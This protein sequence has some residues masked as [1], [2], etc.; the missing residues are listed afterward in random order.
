MGGL[1]RMGIGAVL[2]FDGEAAVASM[3]R[4][5]RSVDHLRQGFGRIGEG[6]RT[7]LGGVTTAAMA[8][9]PAVLA[10]GTAAAAA[11]HKYASFE[12]GLAK[13][14]SLLDGGMA[15][16]KQYSSAIESMALRFGKS[17]DDVSE[18]AFQALSAGIK[19]TEMMD[20]MTEATKG[21]VAGF[22]DTAKSVDV[23]TTAMNAWGDQLG[24]GQTAAQKAKHLNDVL[25]LANKY[26]KTT[27]EEL[28]ASLGNVAGT[29]ATA[30]V[31][32][33][34]VGAAIAAMTAAGISTPE[35]VTALNQALLSFISP[36]K[37]ALKL[38]PGL[39]KLLSLQA[40]RAKGLAG[41]L[42]D[43]T[44]KVQG[45]DEAIAHIFGNVRAFKAVIALTGQGGE[46][47]RK[48]SGE[49]RNMAGITDKV[50]GDVANTL[51]NRFA[52]TTSAAALLA[53]RAGKGLAE[54]LGLAGAG[55]AADLLA[56][57]LDAV[58]QV[59]HRV[60]AAIRGSLERLQVKERIEQIGQVLDTVR[61]KLAE[62]FGGDTAQR[63]TDLA[64][65]GSLIAAALAPVALVLA[66]VVGILAGMITS[67]SGVVSMLGGM[68][69]VATG[70][71]EAFAAVAGIGGGPLALIL[72]A[73]AAAVYAVMA[74]FNGC[75]DSLG[76]L[77][78]S[79][80][81][82]WGAIMR[83]VDVLVSALEPTFTAIA[84]VLGGV[85]S[86]VAGLAAAAME[87]LAPAFELLGSVVGAILSVV[88]T[89][90]AA[91]LPMIGRMFGILGDVIREAVVPA[92]RVV[93]DV[94]RTVSG[95]LQRFVDMLQHGIDSAQRMLGLAKDLPFVNDTPA[96]KDRAA[97]G[98]AVDGAFN[99]VGAGV[100]SAKALAAK[101]GD[102]FGQMLADASGLES[103]VK[104]ELLAMASNKQQ[105]NINNKL[106]V[107]GGAMNVASG[108]ARLELME[109]AGAGV[110]PWQ[111]RQI[112]ERGA[113]TVGAGARG[114]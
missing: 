75:R 71:G 31:P 61:T 60:G 58:E 35:A 65:A 83:V 30:R 107:D 29:A 13:I 46:N 76:A 44:S 87:L 111:R 102:N 33:E 89:P 17:T 108:K 45:N 86:V 28:S 27:F 15:E 10:T 62:T 112:I 5:G 109:R 77:A 23:L 51:D 105:I 59:L 57:K 9:V 74:N 43:V 98:K 36:S 34:E 1:E 37:E 25:F 6:A 26:G 20:F 110:T 38:V 91:V 54:G 22:T 70:V 114:G 113:V 2:D 24:E 52:R 99:M 97:T 8:T 93:G 56:S 67:L 72:A 95:Y 53:T 49:M 41:A 92:M 42:Q 48:W 90:L 106:C 69:A 39:N 11:V 68:G 14:G 18:G 101:A 84:G 85:I 63:L 32:V 16:A 19:A 94:I 100:T 40:I 103:K 55:G 12:T 50:F 4:A 7:A 104:T 47:F 81:T 78:A 80:G 21:A 3:G 73:V 66:P 64:V 79:F 88:L 82:A 96:Q